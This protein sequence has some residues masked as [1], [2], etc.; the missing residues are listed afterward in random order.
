MFRRTFV[1]VF[2]LGFML[3]SGFRSVLGLSALAVGHWSART[4]IT[5][6]A[7]ATSATTSA[8]TR[9]SAARPIAFGVRRL[10][11][12]C[13]LPFGCHGLWH[14]RAPGLIVPGLIPAR[15]IA[16]RLLTAWLI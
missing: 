7:A 5:T 15:F 10:S 13:R 8:T 9:A 1:L 4:L 16:T 11:F 12:T 3:V 14:F 2:V 6:A